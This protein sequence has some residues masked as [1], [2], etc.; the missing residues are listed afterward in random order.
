[1]GIFLL[2]PQ[3]KAQEIQEIRTAFHH[4]NCT[5]VHQFFRDFIRSGRK[6]PSEKSLRN[7]EKGPQAVSAPESGKIHTCPFKALL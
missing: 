2:L 5:K 1:M 7:A 3:G 6:K 4:P